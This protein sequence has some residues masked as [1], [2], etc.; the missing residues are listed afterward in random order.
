V[1]ILI[2]GSGWFAYGWTQRQYYV[3]TDGDYVA[4]FKGVDAGIPGVTLS[5]VYEQ[6]RLQ[7]DRLPTYSR[8]QVEG[9]IQADSLSDARTI[10]GQ[11]QQTADECAAKPTPKP[12]PKPPPVTVSKPVTKAPTKPASKPT[13][14]SPSTPASTPTVPV[15]PND[16]DGVR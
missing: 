5:N 8:E 15:D 3:G 9:T 14:A 7:V 16:C 4:I 13:I 2:G 1:L 6:Q 12:T 10:V 11:L